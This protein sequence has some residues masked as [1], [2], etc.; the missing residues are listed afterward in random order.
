V[1]VLLDLDLIHLDGLLAVVVVE[2]MLL[3]IIWA[4][5][6]QLVEEE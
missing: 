6:N 5:S 2:F 1:S 4:I 3:R